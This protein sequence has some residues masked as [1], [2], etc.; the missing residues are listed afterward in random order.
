[1]ILLAEFNTAYQALIRD[2]APDLAP[3]TVQ[4]ADFAVWQR[5][6]LMG[7]VLDRQ[8]AFWQRQLAGAPTVLDLPT[9]RP[10]PRLQTFAG[11]HLTQALSTGLS[12]RLKALT[13]DEGSTLFMSGLAAFAALLSRYTG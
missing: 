9:D 10:R 4:Y 5:G 11:A 12:G 13:R 3:L 2:E 8:L 7:P 1:R 6:W